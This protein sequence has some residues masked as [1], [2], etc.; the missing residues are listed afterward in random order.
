M[1][2]QFSTTA[3]PFNDETYLESFVESISTS[4]P[5]ELKRN[6]DHLCDLD[7][8]SAQLLEQWRDKQDNC[9]KYV[10]DSLVRKFRCDA[11][12]IDSTTSSLYA[13][14]YY[15]YYAYHTVLEYAY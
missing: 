3:S 14:I 5:N 12:G 15:I 2:Y 4:F 13:Y 11:A 1:T 7:K 10:E 9:C 8:T 6:L